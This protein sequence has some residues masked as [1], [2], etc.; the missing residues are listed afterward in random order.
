MKTLK[1]RW[2]FILFATIVFAGCGSN[3]MEKDAEKLAEIACELRIMAM[4]LD[5]GDIHGLNEFTQKMAQFAEM[6]KQMEEK[7]NLEESDPEFERLIREAL[8]E[9]PCG[10]VELEDLFDF[11]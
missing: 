6:S 10:D 8:K 4:N 11:F 5:E 3:Q 2:G 7:H 9:T 1:R